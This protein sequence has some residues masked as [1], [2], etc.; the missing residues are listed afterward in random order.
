MKGVSSMAKLSVWKEQKLPIL[1]SFK[2]K[3][4]YY[5]T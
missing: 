1:S 5:S 3:D 2:E 4:I